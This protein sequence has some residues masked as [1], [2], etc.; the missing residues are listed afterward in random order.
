MSKRAPAPAPAA[1]KVI[2]RPCFQQDLQWVQLIYAH[3]VATGT[4]TFETIAP[5]L[6]EMTDR[7]AKIAGKGWPFLVACDADDLS[8]VYGYAYAAQF[9]DRQAY[10]KTFEDSVYV[11]PNTLGGGIGK[12]LISGLLTELQEIG[13]QQVIAVIGDSANTASI[14]LHRKAGFHY[15]GTLKGVGQK[16][17][18]QLDVVL[19]QRAVPPKD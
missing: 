13:V 17:G 1:K 7:W 9:R 4:G 6:E 3:H 10:E 5:T 18:R 2:V 15:V 11:S 19:M 14:E 8:R 16:F 12:A